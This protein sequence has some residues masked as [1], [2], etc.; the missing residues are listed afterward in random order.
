MLALAI[1]SSPTHILQ[2]PPRPDNGPV[3]VRAPEVELRLLLLLQ[4]GAQDL[5]LLL[6]DGRRAVARADAGHLEGRRGVDESGRE[7]GR[8]GG[9]V[10]RREKGTGRKGGRR[11]WDVGARKRVC[12][13]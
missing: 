9:R 6:A 5:H 12:G 10:G 2:Q 13:G 4:H 3:E 8:E 11:E 1:P 7:G